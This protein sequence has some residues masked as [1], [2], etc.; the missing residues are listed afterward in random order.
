MKILYVGDSYS[1]VWRIYKLMWI[2]KARFA[3]T[4]PPPAIGVSAEKDTLEWFWDKHFAAGTYPS[5]SSRLHSASLRPLHILFK[6]ILVLTLAANSHSVTHSLTISTVATDCPAFEALPFQSKEYW[7][8]EWFLAGWGMPI[9]ELFDLRDLARTC[10]D[11]KKWTFWFSSVPLNVPGGVASPPC[12]VA[13][14]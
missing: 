2:S 11:L 9:G 13:V 5:L 8:H 12:G 4:N 1:V 14:L 7:I 6:H 3:A 10:A